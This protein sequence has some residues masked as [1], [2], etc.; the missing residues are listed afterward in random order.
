MKQIKI[1]LSTLLITLISFSLLIPGTVFADALSDALSMDVSNINIGT[2]LVP[3]NPETESDT[4]A[5]QLLGLSSGYTAES[6]SYVFQTA[7]LDV[8]E[9][10]NYEKDD[11]DSSHTCAFTIGKGTVY[12]GLSPKEALVI[13][14][15]GTYAAEWY[16]NF[17]FSPSH[18]DDSPFADNFL[19]CAEDAFLTLQKYM[20]EYPDA[21]ILICGHSRGGACANLL[22]LLVNSYTDSQKVYTYTFAA[23]CTV[24][25]TTALPDYPNIFNFLN[26][27]D[28]VPNLPLKN[29]GFVRAGTDIY[30]QNE[31][32]ISAVVSSFITTLSDLAPSIDSY[33]NEQHSIIHNDSMEISISSFELM[34]MFSKWL[35]AMTVES[36]DSAGADDIESMISEEDFKTMISDS[37]FEPLAKLLEELSAND[38]ELGKLLLM[39][40]L[41]ATYLELLTAKYNQ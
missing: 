11:N 41:P 20:E 30:L 18:T 33:Y 12:A 6:S 36:S 39:Q 2:I 37:D 15:R 23:P 28:L 8:L 31:D 3:A 14:I 21:L 22:G 9:Q 19:F 34:L 26:P 35:T 38:Y 13:S 32:A 4:L 1:F 17:D 25:S 24:K 7:G 5:M 10:V 29:W 40:H 16:S 27:C